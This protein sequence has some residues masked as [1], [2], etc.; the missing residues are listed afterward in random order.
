MLSS[1]EAVKMGNNLYKILDVASEDEVWEFQFDEIV[2]CSEKELSDGC[3]LVAI[4]RI[5]K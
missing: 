3:F 4:S 1:S 2:S 5:Q